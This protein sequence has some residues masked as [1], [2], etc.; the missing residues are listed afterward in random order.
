[1]RHFIGQKPA[2]HPFRIVKSGESLLAGSLLL[3]GV[4][5]LKKGKC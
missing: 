3:E 2:Q 4:L 5:E 1:M